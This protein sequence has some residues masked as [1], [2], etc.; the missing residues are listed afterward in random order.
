MLFEKALRRDLTSVAG[1][2]FATLFTIMITTSLIRLLGRAA[3]GRVDTASVFPLIAFS[4]INLLPSLLILTL[5]ISVLTGLTRAYKDSEMVVWFAA[6]LSLTAWIRPVLRF[7]LPFVILVGAL[8]FFVSPWAN[9]QMSEYRQRFEQREDVSQVSAGQFRESVAANRVFFVEALNDDQTAV[10]NVFVSQ[11]KESGRSIVVA[12]SGQIEARG[13]DRFLVL[14]KGRRYDQETASADTRMLEFERYGIRLEP[15]VLAL[16]DESAKIKN[17]MEL[18]ADPKPRHLGELLW[19]IALPVSAVLLALVAIP[20]SFVNPRVGRSVNL[21]VALL[22][23][24]I[25]N[26]LLSLSQ[27]W[28]GQQR[29]SFGVGVWLVHAVLIGLILILFWRRLNL[30]NWRVRLSNS[31]RLGRAKSALEAKR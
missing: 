18:V 3:G 1:V 22:G 29:L 23:Y 31:I 8:A 21:M 27:G 19:R 11:S 13:K 4:A 14:E 16:N 24:I 25:Y 6:G 5:F 30:T 10:K 15:K 7:A 12:A 20:L 28:V 26:N 17:T 9:R 2:V